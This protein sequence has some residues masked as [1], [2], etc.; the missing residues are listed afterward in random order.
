[1]LVNKVIIIHYKAKDRIVSAFAILFINNVIAKTYN[2][3]CFF[4]KKKTMCACSKKSKEYRI[5][6]FDLCR[7]HIINLF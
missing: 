4:K 3:C 5:M 1:M 2:I 7:Y 6:N